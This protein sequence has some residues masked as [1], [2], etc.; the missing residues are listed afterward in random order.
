MPILR[1]PGLIEALTDLGVDL[2]SE[3]LYMGLDIVGD[4]SLGDLSLNY[5]PTL[6]RRLHAR[7]SLA[8]GGAGLFS[9]ASVG[10]VGTGF[11]VIATTNASGTGVNFS[12]DQGTFFASLITTPIN[13]NV[14]GTEQGQIRNGNQ[15]NDMVVSTIST[16]AVAPPPS[17]GYEL[18]NAQYPSPGFF[19]FWVP[20]GGFANWCCIVANT[21]VDFSIALQMPA[22]LRITLP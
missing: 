6:S 13:F 21:A 4:V 8:A 7:V 5:K 20:P 17:T 22:D 11:W 14:V 1:L 10:G 18:T 15:A 9:G 16:Q 19:P 2:A 3:G 12:V